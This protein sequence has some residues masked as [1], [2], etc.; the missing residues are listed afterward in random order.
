M[1]SM[2]LPKS[3]LRPILSE[4]IVSRH[5][6]RHS[7]HHTPLSTFIKP[8]THRQTQ[9]NNMST[10]PPK[11]TDKLQSGLE[12]NKS[13]W[14]PSYAEKF[15]S[16]G[17][18][19]QP[20]ILWIGCSDSRCPETTIL[21]LNPGDVFVHRNIANIIHEGDLSSSC[22]IDF[23]VGALKVQQIVIC[24]HTSCG[25][26][27]AALGDSKLGVLDTWLLPL[28]KLRAQNLG[29]LEK[30]DK[31]S[32]VSKLAE[33]NVLDGMAKIKEKSVV[34]EAMEQRGLKVSGLVYDVATGLL[35]TVDGDEE[36]QEEI[37]ARLTAFKTA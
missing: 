1:A 19:Q 23:A 11:S 27:N 2:Q 37:K 32:A 21:G 28:R 35:R 36:S 9:T 4:S 12:Y 7:C 34:L 33:L 14:A 3:L 8:T 5:L 10:T 22:V 30:L 26:V 15:A 31:K 13:H 6:Q 25:G 18:G 20:Q 16:L 24:G 29:T 17:N